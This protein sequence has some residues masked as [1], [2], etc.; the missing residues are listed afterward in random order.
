MYALYQTQD[1]INDIIA[2][3]FD[4]KYANISTKHLSYTIRTPYVLSN[5]LYKIESEG[6]SLDQAL[7]EVTP[8]V[9]L[10]LCLDESFIKMKAR[11][12]SFKSQVGLL[13]TALIATKN[14]IKHH[15]Y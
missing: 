9:Q 3:I 10:Q 14:F 4:E 8:F 6:P 1:P 13:K 2:V 12:P 11:S 5:I 15:H 7:I